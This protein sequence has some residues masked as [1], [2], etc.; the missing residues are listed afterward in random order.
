M[1]DT[2]STATPEER[3]AVDEIIHRLRTDMVVTI[4]RND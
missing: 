4:T 1:D 3:E 2:K